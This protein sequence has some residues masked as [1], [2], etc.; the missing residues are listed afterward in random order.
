MMLK[1][2]SVPRLPQW[3]LQAAPHWQN[4]FTIAHLGILALSW[5]TIGWLAALVPLSPSPQLVPP[6]KPRDVGDM[7]GWDGLAVWTNHISGLKAQCHPRFPLLEGKWN[8]KHTGWSSGGI[9]HILD[10]FSLS[11]SACVSWLAVVLY[12][13]NSSKNPLFEYNCNQAACIKSANRY[14]LC[15]NFFLI[16]NSI[17]DFFPPLFLSKDTPWKVM[18]ENGWKLIQSLGRYTLLPI[19]I[20]NKKKYTQ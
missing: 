12:Y 1:A 9:S 4:I 20:E 13:C 16:W 18:W 17:C 5:S 15:R 3:S 19:W 14:L 8:C 10:D 7:M 6:S 11:S 2:L